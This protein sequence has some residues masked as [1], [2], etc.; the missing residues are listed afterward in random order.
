M[1]SPSEPPRTPSTAASTAASPSVIGA[2]LKITGNLESAGDIQ[3]DGQV[4]GDIHGRSVTVGEGADVKGAIIADNA[5]VCGTLSGQVRASSVTI[6]KTA[7]ATGDIIHKTLSIEAGAFLEGQ[8]KRLEAEVPKSA[9]QPTAAKPAAA[10][11]K[12][13]PSATSSNSGAGA[14]PTS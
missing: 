10:P 7:K 14:K 1:S 9:A 13:P 2:D 12:A 3:I 6:A 4:E 8:V 11:A 5:R